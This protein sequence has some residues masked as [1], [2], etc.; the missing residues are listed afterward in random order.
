VPPAWWQAAGV[1]RI[2]GGGGKVSITAAIRALPIGLPKII[3]LTVA[4]G[5]TAAYIRLRDNIMMPSAGIRPRSPSPSTS[6]I[7][8]KSDFAAVKPDDRSRL[9][10]SY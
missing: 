10:H 2:G 8:W 3:A 9:V 5:N 4:S 7:S 1:F 6:A